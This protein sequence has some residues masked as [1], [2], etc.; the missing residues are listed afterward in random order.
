MLRIFPRFLILI[1][2]IIFLT[3]CRQSVIEHSDWAAFIQQEE[4]EG[5]IMIFDE[6]DG[7]FHVYDADRCMEQFIPASTYKVFHSLIALETGVIPDSSYLMAWDS[8]E[9]SIP[10]WNRD[11][12]LKTAFRNSVVWYYQRIAREIGEERMLSFLKQEGYGNRDISGGIDMFWLTG[13][14]KI[15]QSEQLQFL[16]KLYHKKLGFTEENM[17]IVKDMMIREEEADYT[18]YGKTGWAIVNST[19]YG[20]FIGFLE[21]NENVYFFATQIAEKGE[22]S[23]TFSQSR[24]D[25]TESALKGLGLLDAPQ[26]PAD[27]TQGS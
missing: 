7:T 23:P 21:Q 15:S 12:S 10:A 27:S 8:T 22:A 14:L 5:S 6:K 25:I 3:S 18:L 17:N 26:P 19:N 1:F 20:W 16:M 13:G 2:G 9:R 24:V 4:R 11:H